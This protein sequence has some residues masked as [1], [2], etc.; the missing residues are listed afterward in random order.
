MP[1]GSN[2]I[3]NDQYQI[4]LLRALCEYRLISLLRFFNLNAQT[5]YH[6]KDLLPHINELYN[7]NVFLS[8]V[9]EEFPKTE[10]SLPFEEY[11]TLKMEKRMG[12]PNTT[13]ATRSSQEASPEVLVKRNSKG[14]FL[15]KNKSTVEKKG[16]DIEKQEESEEETKEKKNYRR[17]TK[18]YTN[19]PKEHRKKK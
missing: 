16:T 2:K 8:D 9:D 18:S 1:S 3:W 5:E 12:S 13:A 6:L 4:I 14:H 15:K 7:I 17:N 10:F 19:S 11:E